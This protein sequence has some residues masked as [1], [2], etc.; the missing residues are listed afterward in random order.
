[1]GSSRARA[2]RTAPQSIQEA[3]QRKDQSKNI[4]GRAISTS[5]VR[6]STSKAVVKRPRSVFVSSGQ[7]KGSGRLSPAT[8]KG[9]QKLSDDFGV[10]TFTTKGKISTVP[11]VQSGGF[12]NINVGKGIFSS[13]EQFA[14]AAVAKSIFQEKPSSTGL[15]KIVT[16]PRNPSREIDT[17][18]GDIVKKLSKLVSDNPIPLGI[19]V[20][21]LVLLLGGKR[22]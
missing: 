1:M 3:Q 8:I 22:R 11:T 16:D 18:N 10:A 14:N 17:S 9:Q 2:R 7:S 12:S 6:Q 13:F 21:V 19:G 5:T 15:P 20:I 4:S